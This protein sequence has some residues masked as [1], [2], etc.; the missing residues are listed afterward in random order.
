[1]KW[2]A[3]LALAMTADGRVP[4]YAAANVPASHGAR[5]L[6][7]VDRIDAAVHSGGN[8]ARPAHLAAPGA[9]I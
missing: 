8:Q 5:P 2:I 9:E 4:I 7:S 1:M 3:S 6:A